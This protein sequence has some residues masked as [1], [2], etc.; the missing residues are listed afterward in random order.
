LLM[1]IARAVGKAHYS[2]QLVTSNGIDH[3]SC[4]GYILTGVRSQDFDWIHTLTKPVILFGEN[5]QDIDFVDSDNRYGTATATKYALKAGYENLIFVGIDVA[6]PFAHEREE[7]YLDVMAENNLS[8]KIF[9]LQ[10]RSTQSEIFIEEHWGSFKENTC[11]ICS[12]D[13][14]AIGIERALINCGGAVPEDFGIIG[15]DGVF[16]DQVSSPKL[17]TM[18]QDIIKMGEACGEMLVKKI[19]ENGQT[20]GYRR[21]LPELVVRESTR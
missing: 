17:T 18:K 3:G 10:N 13:R 6:E 9:R 7:G 16:L 4:D 21:F 14:L 15:F 19:E 11:F 2:L 5:N 1:G 8:P 20:Q 12:S